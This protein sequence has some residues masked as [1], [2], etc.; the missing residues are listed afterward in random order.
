MSIDSL[1][2]AQEKFSLGGKSKST[3]KHY[4]KC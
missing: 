4:E 3:E 1:E 2:A